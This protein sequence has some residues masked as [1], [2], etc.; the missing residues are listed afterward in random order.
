MKT[1]ST[2]H[3]KWSN[4]VIALGAITFGLVTLFL[5]L[6]A[7]DQTIGYGGTAACGAFLT[8]AAS[9]KHLDLILLPG[10][11][12]GGLPSV[13]YI[14]G[15]IVSGSALAVVAIPAMRVKGKTNERT[16]QLWLKETGSLE[17]SL[18]LEYP[19]HRGRN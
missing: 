5:L 17:D 9:L 13:T 4:A 1:D 8:A 19:K 10:P 15:L 14:V 16:S 11:Y 2:R 18:F 6:V 3:R 12:W 7:R